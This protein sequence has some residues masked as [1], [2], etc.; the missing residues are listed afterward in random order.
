[1]GLL[2]VRSLHLASMAVADARLA[3]RP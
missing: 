2:N 3:A 1:V